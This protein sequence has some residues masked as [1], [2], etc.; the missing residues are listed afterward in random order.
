MALVNTAPD[1]LVIAGHDPGGG[2][3][4]QADIE[5]I[6]SNGGHA[7]CVITAHTVQDTRGVQRIVP[8]D[9]ALLRQQLHCLLG[10]LCFAA[11]KIGLLPAAGLVTAVA[12]ILGELP[13]VPVVMDP[14]LASGAGQ[15]LN[16]RE[17]LGRIKSQLL[18]LCTL[19]TPNT[20][21]AMALGDCDAPE[22]AAVAIMAA[23]ADAVYLT[24]THDH[25]GPVINRLY[26]DGKLRDSFPCERLP[27]V[28][29]G[30]GCTLSAALTALLARGLE[31]EQAV[32]EAQRYTLETLRHARHPGRGQKVPDRFFW[33]RDA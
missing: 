22:E 30:S 25:T 28:Y 23:G 12:E 18:P 21:E 32:I 7:A 14:V 13:G 29:H 27:G 19:V 5:A 2:A 17:T 26:A 1:I 8:A 3:G 16:D 15:A 20:P 4:I 6:V 33:I 9:A 31:L 24:G 11:I 10:D